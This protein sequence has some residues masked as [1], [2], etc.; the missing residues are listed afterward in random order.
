M[1]KSI[2]NEIS[3]TKIKEAAIPFSVTNHN[4]I[5]ELL[6][7][8]DVPMYQFVDPSILCMA[9]AYSAAKQYDESGQCCCDCDDCCCC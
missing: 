2:L 6:D 1:I 9:G 8:I 7:T 3:G 4:E 5:S